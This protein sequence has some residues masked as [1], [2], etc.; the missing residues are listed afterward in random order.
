VG[1]TGWA[2]PFQ[3]DAVL[4]NRAGKKG[5][6]MGGGGGGTFSGLQ[7]KTLGRQLEARN[8]DANVA[9]CARGEGLGQETV[10]NGPSLYF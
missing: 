7:R 4:R 6:L 5:I 2:Q 10:F 1:L 3:L 9:K 8:K